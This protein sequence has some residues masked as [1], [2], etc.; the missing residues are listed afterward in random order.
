M[1]LKKCIEKLMHKQNLSS[2]ECKQVINEIII[3]DTNVL[4]IAAFL[5]LLRA[6]PETPDEIVGIVK[7]LREI[8]TRVPIMDKLIDI[9]GTGGDSAKTINISTGSAILAASCGAKVAKSGNRASTSQCG[10]ADVLEQLGISLAISGEKI[11]AGIDQFG[12]GFFFSPNFNPAMQYLRNLRK[13]LNVPTTFNLIGP[14]L[15]PAQATH[16]LYGVY[17]EK[18]L[19][20]IAEVT[21]RLGVERA[22]I[23]HG[24]GLDEISCLGLTK[25]IEVT[26]NGIKKLIIDPVQL[27]FNI[28]HL[29]DIQGGTAELNAKL[30]L[31]ALSG[32]SSAIADTLILNAAVALW[33]YGMY[34]SITDAI[35]HIKENISNGNALK[36]LKRWVEYS[37]E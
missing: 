13:Q 16:Y 19:E 6:K 37:N 14:L 28:C 20:V 34:P 24:N 15:H 22:L 33:V 4:Q 7:T 27:G 9:V 25:A 12:I 8:M 23:V 1:I 17:D 21:Y 5:V 30:L 18:L 29:A 11:A 2:E 3:E 31:D 32:K 35:P 26:Q 10:A 36:L